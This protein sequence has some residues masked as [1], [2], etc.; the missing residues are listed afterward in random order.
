MLIAVTLLAVWLG[1]H[2]HSTS[3]QKQSAAVIHDCGGSVRYD[4]QYPKGRYGPNDFS[5][6][7]TSPVPKWLQDSVGVDFFHDVVAVKVSRK[8][9]YGRQ[10]PDADDGLFRCLHGFPDLRRLELTHCGITDKGLRRLPAFASLESL[11]LS[12]SS[13]TD[14]GMPHVAGLKS[15]RW[16]DLA[17]TRVSGR[18]FHRLSRLEQLETLNLSYT[19]VR[20]EAIRSVEGIRT[21]RFVSVFGCRYLTRGGV[22]AFQEAAPNCRLAG[23][24]QVR[25]FW[26]DK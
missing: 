7:A 14:D 17:H 2:I 6:S 18:G 11:E 24:Y 26:A 8:Y 21:L 16:L 20:D 25:R 9:D 23:L 10:N 13:V 12:Y 19:P 3:L 4:F 1:A 5:Y 22:A 15:L